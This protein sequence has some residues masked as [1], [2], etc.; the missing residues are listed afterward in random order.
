[1]IFND[2]NYKYGVYCSLMTGNTVLVN[3]GY[4]V[5]TFHSDNDFEQKG[6]LLA[7]SAVQSSKYEARTSTAENE[8]KVIKHHIS[9]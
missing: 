3:G 9:E 5:I 2:Q 1:M 8:K 4:V 7:F 6:F